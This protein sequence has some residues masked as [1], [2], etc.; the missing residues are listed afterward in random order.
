MH[1]NV[2]GYALSGNLSDEVQI[3]N[4]ATRSVLQQCHRI[5]DYNI[6]RLEPP[7]W[8]YEH[9]NSEQTGFLSCSLMLC[10]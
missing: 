10:C 9:P 5:V 6:V 7:R 3:N 8:S 4:V 1:E 2:Y